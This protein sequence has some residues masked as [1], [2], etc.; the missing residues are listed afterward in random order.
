MKIGKVIWVATDPNGKQY[1]FD[2]EPEQNEE[3]VFTSDD[4]RSEQ[5]GFPLSQMIAVPV[6]KKIKLLL[7]AEEIQ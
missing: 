1:W 6:G 2:D 3:D 4:G 5:M 7:I